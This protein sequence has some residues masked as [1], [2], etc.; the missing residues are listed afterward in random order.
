MR[1][2][3]TFCVDFIEFAFLV[4]A[5]IPPRPIARSMFWTRVVDEY[6]NQMTDEERGRLYEWIGMNPGYQDQKEKGN[7]DCLL[8]DARFNPDNQ[9][10]VFTDYE[11]NHEAFHC[12]KLGDRYCTSS[13]TSILDKYITEVQKIVT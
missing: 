9:Y 1:N 5:C 6:Y 13:T 4:E 3:R 11:G 7:I 10:R 12:F 2:E 8:F